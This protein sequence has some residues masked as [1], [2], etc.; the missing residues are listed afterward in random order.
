MS[1]RNTPEINAGSMADIAFLLLIFFLVTTT[2]D[3]E[4]GIQKMLSN[5]ETPPRQPVNERN[6]LEI[7]INANNEIQLEG[8]KI[9]PIENLKQFVVDF[10]DNGAKVD[11]NGSPC[12]WCNGKKDIT[13]SDHPSKAVVAL[14]SSRS[15][16]YGTYIAAHDEINSA[17]AELRNKLAMSLYGNSYEE[18]LAAQK[19]D[20]NNHVLT[21]QIDDVKKK[22]PVLIFDQEAIK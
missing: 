4:I 22:Y 21:A 12:G 7:A 13:S 6:V 10:I 8:S 19:N 11:L 2:L 16:S 15:T 18:L 20:K 5:K 1:N 3:S 17:Y 9:I 14:E